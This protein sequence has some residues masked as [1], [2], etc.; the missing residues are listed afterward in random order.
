MEVR[1]TDVLGERGWILIVD[2][3]TPTGTE[4]RTVPDRGPATAPAQSR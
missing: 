2:M 4:T 3:D 1:W